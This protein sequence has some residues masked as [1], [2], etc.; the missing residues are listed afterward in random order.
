[1][2]ITKVLRWEIGNLQKDVGYKTCSERKSFPEL[3]LSMH[4]QEGSTEYAC[5]GGV[6]WVCMYRRGQLSM[7]GQEGSTEC[8]WTR[9]VK[10][11]QQQTTGSPCLLTTDK[12]IRWS[13]DGKSTNERRDQSKDW[14]ELVLCSWEVFI[15]VQGYVWGQISWTLWEC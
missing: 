6:N 4:V 14:L 12:G 10:W 13:A 5:T 15:L 8:V 7:H 9:V 1:M 11:Q 3:E 2:H